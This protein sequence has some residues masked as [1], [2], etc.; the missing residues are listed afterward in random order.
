MAL[1]H[2]TACISSFILNGVW[3]KL[4]VLSWIEG[5]FTLRVIFVLN[6]VKVSNPQMLTFTQISVG[7]PARSWAKRVL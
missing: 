7:Y 1:K 6:R 2:K 5:V 4:R 3:L